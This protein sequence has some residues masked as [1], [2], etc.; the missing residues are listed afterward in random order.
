MDASNFKSDLQ[1]ETQ[2]ST[3]LDRLYHKHLRFYDFERISDLNLQLKGVDLIFT[4][5][6]DQKAFYI[7]EKAQLDYINDDLPTFAFELSYQKNGSLR[8]GWLFDPSKKT[9]F[10]ALVTAI[11]SDEPQRYTSCKI[12]MVNRANLL[13][14]LKT[15][16]L[17]QENLENYQKEVNGKH[18]KF[19]LKELHSHSEGY[20]YSSTK[21]K[22]EKPL[23]LIL[24]LDFLIENGVAKRL[25]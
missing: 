24:K 23:N 1:K 9:D 14:F 21:N 4:K 22:A 10:Y 15:K 17:T 12:T 5:K 6:S 11:Y 3:L 16:N 19:V 13:T 25:I 18:G 2:L 8:Q 7:D 20:L